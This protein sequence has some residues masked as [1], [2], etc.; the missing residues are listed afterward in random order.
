MRFKYKFSTLFEKELDI[1]DIGNC[2][3]E[4][5][6]C[7]NQHY[8]LVIKTSLGTTSFFEYGP[9][10]PDIKLL[11]KYV[12]NTFNRIEFS[13]YKMEKR[14]N[15]FLTNAEEVNIIDKDKALNSCVNLIEYFRDENNY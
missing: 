2:A 6:D 10:V 12:H 8:Y 14:I 11:P 7:K 3:I 15:T 9:I 5:I 1:E 13:E 4:V